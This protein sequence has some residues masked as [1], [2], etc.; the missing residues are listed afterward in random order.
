MR[1][2]FFHGEEKMLPP[3]VLLLAPKRFNFNIQNQDG[4]E[5]PVE[6]VGEGQ[7]RSMSKTHLEDIVT[8]SA[9]CILSWY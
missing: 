3:V 1:F 8:A 2:G 5:L 7:L 9:A 6:Q 4:T